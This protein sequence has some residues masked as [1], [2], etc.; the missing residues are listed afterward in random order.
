[1]SCHSKAIL[2]MDRSMV[3]DVPFATQIEDIKRYISDFEKSKNNNNHFVNRNGYQYIHN[4]KSTHNFLNYGKLNQPHLNQYKN[5]YKTFTYSSKTPSN[6]GI[7]FSN[8]NR[9]NDLSIDDN[10]NDPLKSKL[11]KLL[12]NHNLWYKEKS[13]NIF[14]NTYKGHQN[15]FQNDSQLRSKTGHGNILH[16]GLNISNQ[17]NGI[18]PT[19]HSNFSDMNFNQSRNNF[20]NNQKI[21]NWDKYQ[22]SFD[23]RKTLMMKSL[24]ETYSS[25][26]TSNKLEPYQVLDTAHNVKIKS[27]T[28]N[29][30][31]SHFLMLTDNSIRSNDNQLLFSNFPDTSFRDKFAF[32]PTSFKITNSNTYSCNINS[33][34]EDMFSSTLNNN[35]TNS[36]SPITSNETTLNNKISSLYSTVINPTSA[37][38]T[39]INNS[40]RSNDIYMPFVLMAHTNSFT[41]HYF[42]YPN[43]NINQKMSLLQHNIHDITS[44][45]DCTMSIAALD[46]FFLILKM[47]IVMK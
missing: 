42:N 13:D 44:E 33:S 22:D 10:I 28:N 39:C 27:D 19:Y 37:N 3:S 18:T 17:L 5:N 16:Q 31:K 15:N 14:Y 11:R 43:S 7:G 46:W 38:G 9:R 45:Y 47:K 21:S 25:D 24:Y 32:L 6:K 36:L 26:I 20:G 29:N 30:N 23:P 41:N 8:S 1:M 4:L 40:S 35:L 34:M 2:V 12:Y